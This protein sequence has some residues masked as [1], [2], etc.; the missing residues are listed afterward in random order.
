MPL[1]ALFFLAL[2]ALPHHCFG[3]DRAALDYKVELD[4]KVLRV[5]DHN[6]KL[7][8]Q[9]LVYDN[10]HLY[11]SSGH[12]ARSR[13]VRYP[14]AGTA[15]NWFSR[16]F[17]NNKHQRHIERSIFAEGLTLLNEKLYLLSWKSGRAFSFSAKTLKPLDEFSYSGQGWGLTHNGSE[18]IRSDGSDYLYFHSAKDF[19]VTKRLWVKG[20]GRAWQNINELEYVDGLVWANIWQENIVI[21]INADS[22]QVE[23]TVDLSDLV[24]LENPKKSD[25]VLNGIAYDRDQKVF[26][27]T[28]KYWKNLYLIRLQPTTQLK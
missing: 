16:L 8:T 15:K 26:W 2:I 17:S 19:S 28:G 24:Q 12:Y 20:Q 10:G 3:S 7:F 21:A 9:G 4:Y 5:I 22:G 1:I 13:L 18:L 11:E 6:S 23:H 14:V 27:V 25:A